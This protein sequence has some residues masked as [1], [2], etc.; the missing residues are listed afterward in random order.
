MLTRES[1]VHRVATLAA[2]ASVV[3]ASLVG[4]GNKY[5]MVRGFQQLWDLPELLGH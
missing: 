4:P 5:R 3:F 1:P 2:V